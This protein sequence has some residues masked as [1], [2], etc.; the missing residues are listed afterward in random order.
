MSKM[1]NPV[2]YPHTV[3]AVYN[4]GD[5]I[6]FLYTKGLTTVGKKEICAFQ[7]PRSSV[8]EVHRLIN[9]LSTRDYNENEGIDSEGVLFKLHSVKG[10]RLASLRRTHL[11]QM[12]SGAKVLELKP[13]CCWMQGHGTVPE[14]CMCIECQAS[15]GS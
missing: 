5:A 8:Q 14:Q 4:P 2:K 12:D 15:T 6:G 1:N 3:L 11:C 13:L 10:P 7:V 9:F